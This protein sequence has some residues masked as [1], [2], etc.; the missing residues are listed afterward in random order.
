MPPLTLAPLTPPFLPST[1]P[2]H[3]PPAAPPQRWPVPQ[4]ESQEV[5]WRATEAKPSEAVMNFTRVLSGK[6]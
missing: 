5:G 6:A 1:P 4:T 3:S 2:P